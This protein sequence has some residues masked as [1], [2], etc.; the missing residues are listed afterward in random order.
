[1]GMF[2]WET[3]VACAVVI[4]CLALIPQIR[5]AERKE[6]FLAITSAI[7]LAIWQPEGL[8]ITVGMTAIAWLS[9]RGCA[10]ESGPRSVIPTSIGVI[11]LLIPLLISKTLPGLLFS[12]WPDSGP[13]LTRWFAPLGLSFTSFR[14]IGVLLDSS[15]LKIPVSSSRLALLSLFFP[16]IPSGPITTLQSL[17]DIGK[18]TTWFSELLPAGERILLGIARKVLLAD[19][20]KQFV[21]DP[22]LANGVGQLE[23]YQCLVM[24]VVFG[25]YIYWDF[26]GYS[27]MA[28]GIAKLLGYKVPENFNRPYMSRNLVDFWRRWHITLSEWIRIRL[29]MKIAGRRAGIGRLSAATI[30]SMALCGLWHGVGFGY[31]LWG[32]WHGVGLVVVHLFGEA[33]KRSERLQDVA[34][35][36]FGAFGSTILTF[37]YVTIGWVWFFLPLGDGVALIQRGMQ[38]R[39][40]KAIEF[41]VPLGLTAALFAAYAVRE[42]GNRLW[43]RLPPSVRGTVLAGLLGLVTYALLY[44]HG[45]KQEFI[46]TQF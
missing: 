38:W 20:L 31:L 26:S 32:V 35:R 25:M 14:L 8:L 28:I 3:A 29:M 40:G 46:Y 37:I 5:T 45:V 19:S 41:L 24:P 15:A 18:G 43:E 23:P 22:W 21:I 34:H 30:I 27:D 17:K 2:G 11:L 13:D 6:W 7:V 4:T 36:M 39:G 9:I 12:S 16:T 44:R 42:Q 1:M 33:Q 10:K